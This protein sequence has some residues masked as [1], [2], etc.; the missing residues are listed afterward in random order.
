MC[1]LCNIPDIMGQSSHEQ[2]RRGSEEKP[3]TPYQPRGH[4]VAVDTRIAG[5]FS[6][7]ADRHQCGKK[8]RDKAERSTARGYVRIASSFHEAWQGRWQPSILVS[9]VRQVLSLFW[10]FTSKFFWIDTLPVWRR[11]W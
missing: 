1:V 6:S 8:V 11:V 5:L 3:E 7:P 10:F 4:A 9:P 2:R